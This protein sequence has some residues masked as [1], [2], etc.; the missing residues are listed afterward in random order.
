MTDPP[1]WTARLRAERKSRGWDVHTMARRLREAAGDDR[2]DLPDHEALV[3]SIRRWES[4]KIT[5]LTERYRLLFSQALGTS[6]ER[7][8]SKV[9]E[10]SRPRLPS[11]DHHALNAM[12]SFRGADRRVGGGH[13]YATVL[14]YLERNIGP[15]LFSAADG[16]AAFVA[17]AAFT[18]MAGWMAHDAGQD[19]TAERHFSRALD[20]AGMGGDRQLEAHVLGSMSHLALHLGRT[21]EAVRHAY[22]GTTLLADTRTT[23]PPIHG[24]LL[25][26]AAHGLARMSQPANCIRL[27]HQAEQALER[28]HGDDR[29]PW[30]GPFDEGALALSTARCMLALGQLGEARSQADRAIALRPADRTRS[31]ALGR[32][33]LAKTLLAEGDQDEACRM[34]LVVA[35]DTQSLSSLVV[36]R[37]LAEVGTRL[38]AYRDE[39]RVAEC[40]ALLNETLRKRH[41]LY[42]WRSSGHGA[43]SAA[44]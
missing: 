24:R 15:H 7:L 5:Q 14:G 32:L 12:S 6:E 20:L 13:L 35:A 28:G 43:G 1:R 38:G 26:M 17:A 25:A 18:E 39:R 2:R 11:G 34:V 44:L 33:V 22:R 37:Q 10:T 41:W 30:T 42:E 9:E 27:L 3:R 40:L 16:A 4:G 23:A 31:R 29:S 36:T 21:D 19:V 8:F